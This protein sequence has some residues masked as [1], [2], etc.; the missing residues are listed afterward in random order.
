MKQIMPWE[1]YSRLAGQEIV[2]FLW[3][4]KYNTMFTKSL[5]PILYPPNS[6]YILKFYFFMICFNI[7]QPFMI[8][9]LFA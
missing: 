5:V 6:V 3:N 8:Y 2:L 9:K 1:N 7:T 4:P